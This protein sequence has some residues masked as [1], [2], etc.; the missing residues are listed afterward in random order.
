MRKSEIT[1]RPEVSRNPETPGDPGSG[2]YG[3]RVV[4]RAGV[5]GPPIS[6]VTDGEWPYGTIENPVTGY[7]QE[8]ARRLAKAIGDKSFRSVAR[9]AGV[10]HTTIMAAVRGERWPDL[11]TLARLEVALEARLWPGGDS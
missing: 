5:D 6:Y 3:G 9:E 10:D 8:V 2:G 1:S 7:A 11:I 4:R